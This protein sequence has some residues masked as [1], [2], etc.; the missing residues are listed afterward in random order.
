MIPGMQKLF[1]DDIASD[2]RPLSRQFSLRRVCK[3]WRDEIIPGARVRCGVIPVPRNKPFCFP[4][5]TWSPN[6][7]DLIIGDEMRKVSSWN[8]R[9]I[10]DGIVATELSHTGSM[11]IS[12]SKNRIDQSIPQYDVIATLDKTH[13]SHLN[14][15]L[16]GHGYY[17]KC[18]TASVSFRCDDR[19]VVV[20]NEVFSVA[21]GGA[22]KGALF[23]VSNTGNRCNSTVAWSP[24]AIE[25]LVYSAPCEYEGME[26]YTTIN[27]VDLNVQASSVNGNVVESS[28]NNE[29]GC[30]VF[31]LPSGMEYIV[32]MPSGVCEFHDMREQ[33]NRPSRAFSEEFVGGSVYWNVAKNGTLIVRGQS[34]GH[35]QIFDIRKV[36]AND[37]RSM[38][39]DVALLGYKKMAS[40]IALSPDAKY[41]AVTYYNQRDECLVVDIDILVRDYARLTFGQFEM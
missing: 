27:V 19:F 10:F 5:C 9:F 35:I 2:A 28:I 6:F 14:A 26:K 34:D 15:S 32:T 22:A 37:K 16:N 4:Q 24:T 25:R 38:L 36:M 40:S 12:A 11:A 33:F 13:I 31:W 18:I 21:E 23:D 7:D 30:H 20:G 17:D 41:M 1:A 3:T 29:S 8:T 39:C